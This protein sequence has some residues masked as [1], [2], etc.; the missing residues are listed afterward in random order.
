MSS[1]PNPLPNPAQLTLPQSELSG[2]YT[3]NGDLTLA[4]RF[5]GVLHTTG[6]VLVTESANVTGELY[7][8]NVRIRGRFDGQLVAAGGL[9]LQGDGVCIGKVQAAWLS[10][11]ENARLQAEL[12]LGTQSEAA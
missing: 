12:A 4:G 6:D 11:G 7:A 3:H 5:D 10:T 8:T 1:A 2:R 9:V